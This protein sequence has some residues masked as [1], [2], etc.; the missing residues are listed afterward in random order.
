VLDS[1]LGSGS[2]LM[3]AQRTGRVC[4]GVELDPIYVDTIVRRWQRET[5]RDAVQAESKQRFNEMEVR[6]VSG[7]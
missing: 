6:D 4:Y 3:A 5:G 7:R 2:T 1:F